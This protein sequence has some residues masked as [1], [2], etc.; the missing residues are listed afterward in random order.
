MYSTSR[1]SSVHR[2]VPDLPEEKLGLHR[3]EHHLDGRGVLLEQALE[4][5][6]P[7][8]RGHDN[9]VNFVVRINKDNLGTVKTA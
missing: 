8:P 1:H 5:P 2:F 4:L 3:R 9:Y 7:G 6:V